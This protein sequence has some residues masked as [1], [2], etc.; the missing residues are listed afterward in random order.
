MA[1]VGTELDRCQRILR[2]TTMV[3]QDGTFWSRAEL[4]AYFQDGYRHMLAETSATRRF[5]VLDVPARFPWAITHPW[6]VAFCQDGPAFGWAF[7][8]EGDWAVTHLW[9]LEVL[10][11]IAGTAAGE[12]TV[13]QPWQR[14]FGNPVQQH[15][16][17]AV[18]R[19]SERVIKIW[20]NN[21]LLIPLAT[22]ALD[23]LETH[24]YSL[25]GEPIAWTL[26]IGPN[27]T[28]EVF[29]I[30]TAYSANY[31]HVDSVTLDGNPMHGIVRR[32]TGDRTYAWVSDTGDTIP[33]GLARRVVSDDRQYYPRLTEPL[34]F[35][36]GRSGWFAGSGDALLVL[37][38]RIP[39]EGTL[40]EEDEAVLL[41]P[42]MGKYLR[43]YTLM[44]AFN[45]QGEGHNGLMAAWFEQ[46][47]ARGILFLRRLHQLAR[48][49]RR[50][51]RGPVQA[52]RRRPPRVRL[53]SAY[54]AVLP[55]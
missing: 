7:Q 18:P 25:D 24:W 55:P 12:I 2:D 35:P 20:Y 49:D 26:G 52:T 50:V 21:K 33:Y 38:A 37:E 16:R 11:G 13:T 1:T 30:Q 44:R 4:L 41:P 34:R 43:W 29:E 42:Q 47:Y 48:K 22:R 40:A 19:D 17:F 14:A 31:A 53:P 5:T 9:E 46:R 27:R 6:Q 51:Q 3:G 54:P 28:V 36:L 23:S 8:G 15:F 39:D 10:E 45:R 32:L